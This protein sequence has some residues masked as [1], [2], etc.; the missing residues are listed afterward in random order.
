MICR[1]RGADQ[2]TRGG[3]FQRV[4]ARR[5]WAKGGVD[6]AEVETGDGDGSNR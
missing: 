3:G 4:S 2:I 5:A 6:A 1:R